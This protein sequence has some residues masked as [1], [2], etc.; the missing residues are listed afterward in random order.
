MPLFKR[1]GLSLKMTIEKHDRLSGYARTLLNRRYTAYIVTV[2]VYAHG[3]NNHAEFEKHSGGSCWPP[4]HVIPVN[5]D[6][7]HRVEIMLTTASW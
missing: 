2:T 3:R 7:E 5:P 6:H 4:E 1:K